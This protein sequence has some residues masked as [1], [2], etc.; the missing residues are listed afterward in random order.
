M[1]WKYFH[2]QEYNINLTSNDSRAVRSVKLFPQSAIFV[3]HTSRRAL[4]G[5]PEDCRSADF[6][7]K[8]IL[9]V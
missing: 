5:G 4:P 2:K 9:Y 8:L 1:M 3:D 7:T 6:S